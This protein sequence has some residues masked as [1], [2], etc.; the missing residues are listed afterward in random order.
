MAGLDTATLRIAF[1]FMALALTALFYF[2]TYRPTRS[3]YSKWWCVALMF[4][5]GGSVCF[6]LNG[7]VAQVWANPLGNVMLVSGVLSVWAGARSL[8]ALSLR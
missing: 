4:F 2:C 7:T 5:L 8:R 3:P 1:G 6:L